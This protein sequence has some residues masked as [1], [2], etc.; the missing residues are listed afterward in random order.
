MNRAKF[1]LEGRIQP[2]R[3]LPSLLKRKKM[4][5]P[6]NNFQTAI[7]IWLQLPK[8][9]NGDKKIKAT[10]NDCYFKRYG[11]NLYKNKARL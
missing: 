7:F 2:N 9:C 8:N 10:K 1:F 3:I 4:N 6:K 5:S 11:C